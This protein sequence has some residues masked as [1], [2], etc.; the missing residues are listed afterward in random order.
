[1]AIA[2]LLAQPGVIT[3]PKAVR[4]EHVRALAA[5]GELRLDAEDLARIDRHFP[6]PRQA[7]PLTIV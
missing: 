2:W 7:Q 4:A 3:I 1:M 5:A 6:P